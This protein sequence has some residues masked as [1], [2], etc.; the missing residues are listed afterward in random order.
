[1]VRTSES[2][3]SIRNIEKA[4]RNRHGS[5]TAEAG[6]VNEDVSTTATQS[7]ESE[8]VPQKKL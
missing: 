1:M 8:T 5:T 4:A 7:T 3:H 6:P 2:P